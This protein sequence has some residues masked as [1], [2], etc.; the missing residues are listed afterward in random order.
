[1]EKI[2]FDVKS[3]FSNPGVSRSFGSRLRWM[4][5]W[6]ALDCRD[7]LLRV[8][9]HLPTNRARIDAYRILGMQI[10]PYARFGR[11]CLVLGGPQRICI[12]RGSV[13]NRGVTLDGRFPLTIGANVS[14][15]IYT[16]ILT[17]QHEINSPDFHLAGAPVTIGDRVFIGTR[18][19]IM[20]GV[21]I[22]E[23]SVVAAGAVVTK[24]VEPFAIV[25]GVPAKRIGA[26]DRNLTY[27]FADTRP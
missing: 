2:A 14:I 27:E 20:P 7:L 4:A 5:S 15:S 6:Y 16:V 3:G 22:G 21:T 11:H 13:I 26:R 9:D 19:M 25:A 1:M 10:G 24:D 17:L 18:A 12:G 8:I 23:G